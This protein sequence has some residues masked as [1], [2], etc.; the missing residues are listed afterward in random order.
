[1]RAAWTGWMVLWAA[2]LL[3]GVGSAHAV[4]TASITITGNVQPNDAAAITLIFDGFSETVAYDATSTANSIASAIAIRFSRNYLASGLCAAAV[5]NVVTFKLKTGGI[6]ALSVVNSDVSFHVAGTGFPPYETLPTGRIL[7]FFP[8]EIGGS[9]VGLTSVLLT[10]SDTVD[11][12]ILSN[13]CS[14]T[15]PG[16]GNC[17]IQVLFA[18]FTHGTKSALLQVVSTGAGSPNVVR[19]ALSW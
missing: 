3:G 7:T 8:S 16:G 9:S 5:G 11:Y 15:L 10:G 6:G 14:G 4:S 12:Q 18:P 19:L 17:Q 2:V 1:M 13:S